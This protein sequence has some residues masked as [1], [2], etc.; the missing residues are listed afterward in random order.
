MGGVL[1]F[2]DG[3]AAAA[4][5][6][7]MRDLRCSMVNI[8]PDTASSAPEVLKAVV[9]ATQNTAGV[10]GAVTHIGPVAVGQTL[11]LHAGRIISE[12]AR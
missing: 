11:F 4:I 5:S 7:T 6:V 1:S 9:R 8:D 10:Y 3:D 2:G 12:R